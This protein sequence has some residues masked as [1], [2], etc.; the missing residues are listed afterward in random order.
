MNQ[1]GGSERETFHSLCQ[2]SVLNCSK[3]LSLRSKIHSRRVES[4]MSHH[5]PY[6]PSFYLRLQLAYPRSKR[7]IMIFGYIYTVTPH[8]PIPPLARS[9]PCCHML[10]MYLSHPM[11]DARREVITRSHLRRTLTTCRVR[12]VCERSTSTMREGL[13]YLKQV[14]GENTNRSLATHSSQLH[15]PIE[16]RRCR[17]TV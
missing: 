12:R 9:L 1:E 15:G 16:K 5:C 13:S 3:R 2:C 8:S 14:L 6:I 11:H 4:D 7:A 17:I 10:P